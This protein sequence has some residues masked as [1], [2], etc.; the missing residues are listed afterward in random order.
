[1]KSKLW[2]IISLSLAGVLVL[3]TIL[4]A[5]MSKSYKPELLQQPNT[6]SVANQT[7]NGFY[8]TGLA[9]EGQDEE[10]YNEIMSKFSSSFE[11]SILASMLNG[12]LNAEITISYSSSLPAKDG[13]RVTLFYPT[14]TLKLNGEAYKPSG[15]EI[16]FQELSFDVKDGFGFNSVD[17]YAKV[18]SGSSTGYYK[19]T[20]LA[21]TKAMF[22]V[23]SE[24]NYL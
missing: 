4:L 17:L 16:T 9:Y 8:W 2:L 1:M 21:S 11:Q 14:T 24:L 7:G 19:I 6:I 20:T 3:S 23:L 15:S 12:N 22:D 10:N 18:T 5:V 13:Y